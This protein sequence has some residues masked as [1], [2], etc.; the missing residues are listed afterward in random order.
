MNLNKSKTMKK[1]FLI[2]SMLCLAIACKKEGIE[3]TTDTEQEIPNNSEEPIPN[4]PNTA[5]LN[6]DKIKYYVSID[7][8]DIDKFYL[9]YDTQ[10]RIIERYL[11]NSLSLTYIYNTNNT[12]TINTI[13]NNITVDTEI[14]TLN[15]KG[16]NTE[17][18]RSYS[19]EGYSLG[20]NNN[21]YTITV[22][23]ENVIEKLYEDGRRTVYEFYTN[24]INT[25]GEY[26]QGI[27]F[28]GKDNANLV[29]KWYG[30]S[31]SGDTLSYSS[32]QYTFDSK[33]RAITEIVKYYSRLNNSNPFVLGEENFHEIEY[34]D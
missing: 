19:V 8:T 14:L 5:L 29:K 2:A 18:G 22:E 25:I 27:A 17:D 30:I 3:P 11:N 20:Q 28:E 16:F 34:Y 13:D 6:I 1:I 15:S 24:K 9:K 31:S 21:R 26:N 10:G 23:N 4:N 7:G 12:L 33:D 32:F